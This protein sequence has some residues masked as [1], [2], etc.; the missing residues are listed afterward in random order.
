MRRARFAALKMRL[1][2]KNTFCRAAIA[3]EQTP[4]VPLGHLDTFDATLF[5]ML[6]QL[7]QSGL[8]TV[9]EKIMN[10]F[11]F[12]LSRRAPTP[13]ENFIIIVLGRRTKFNFEV[14][15]NRLPVVLSQF[16]LKGF[17]LAF[18]CTDNVAAMV[19]SKQ[20]RFSGLSLP[21]SII[22]MRSA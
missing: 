10:G 1:N 7:A 5:T 22:Q 8:D 6:L 9:D 12:R 15:V 17:E 2:T 16:M 4:D 19:L 3:F 14:L 11:F 13:N 18:R 20:A 21:R